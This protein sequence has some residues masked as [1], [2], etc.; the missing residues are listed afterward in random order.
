MFLDKLSV[1]LWIFWYKMFAFIISSSKCFFQRFLL[2]FKIFVSVFWS[3]LRESESTFRFFCNRIL[4]KI[5]FLVRWFCRRSHAS[6]IINKFRKSVKYFANIF[7]IPVSSD[8]DFSEI[9]I[10]SPYYTIKRHVIQRF[11]STFW[12][13]RS[14]IS[15]PLFLKSFPSW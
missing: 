6:G 15:C 10:F 12:R 2:Y 5:G 8:S 13:I 11:D 4:I 3:V 9:K 7:Y 14:I 1:S